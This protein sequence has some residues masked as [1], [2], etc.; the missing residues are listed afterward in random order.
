MERVFFSYNDVSQ[1]SNTNVHNYLINCIVLVLRNSLC[2]NDDYR[3]SMW[4]R[5]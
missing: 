4:R 5:G 2:E 1:Q 3:T